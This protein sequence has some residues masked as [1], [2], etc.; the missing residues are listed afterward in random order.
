MKKRKRRVRAP[1]PIPLVAGGPVVVTYARVSPPTPQGSHAEKEDSIMRIGAWIT[2]AVL[3][4]AVSSATA[5]P[6]VVAIEEF[7]NVD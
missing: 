5:A 1:A 4:G 6:R 3:L 7:T 2:G